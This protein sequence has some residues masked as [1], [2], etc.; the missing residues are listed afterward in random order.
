MRTLIMKELLTVSGG[1]R[2]GDI[3]PEVQRELE[4]AYR[5]ARNSGLTHDEAMN[6]CQSLGDGLSLVTGKAGQSLGQAT[7]EFCRLAAKT[8][9]SNLDKSPAAICEQ[10]QGGR[11]DSQERTC[12]Q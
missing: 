6:A 10:A 1:Q 7:D 11:W 3:P 9:I 2:G 12:I 5:D 8:W 4:N